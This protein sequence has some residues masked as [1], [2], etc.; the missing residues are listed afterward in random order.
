[1]VAQEIKEPYFDESPDEVVAWGA[2]LVAASLGTPEED[3]TPDI[4]RVTEVT[5]HSLGVGLLKDKKEYGFYP[6]IRRNSEYPCKAAL[7]GVTIRPYQSEV[8]IRVYRGEH[9][10]PHK[11]Y[12]L[13]ELT[14]RVKRPSPNEVP[15]AA[16]FRLDNDGILHFTAVDIPLDRGAAPAV[17]TLLDGAASNDGVLDV[18]LLESLIE[19]QTLQ[20]PEEITIDP[21]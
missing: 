12:Y 17:L 7:L 20:Q 19:N 15:I 13:G 9:T 11:N 8:V 21:R 2:A 5:A 4:I 18:T 16:M 3:L 14:L 10:D 6:L 1:M